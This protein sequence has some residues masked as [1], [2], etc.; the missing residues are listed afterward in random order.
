MKLAAV[1][2]AKGSR[3][4]TIEPAAEISVAIA[5]LADNNIGA[6]IV[7]DDAGAPVGILSERD[8]IRAFARGGEVLG[9]NVADLMTSPVISG[10]SNDDLDGVLRTMTARRFRHLPVVDGGV[11][12]GMVTIGDLVKAQLSAFRGAVETLESRLLEAR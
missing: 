9:A 1:L 6:L 7:V 2:A 3:V 11:L 10:T 8:I 5:R 12:V 4:F